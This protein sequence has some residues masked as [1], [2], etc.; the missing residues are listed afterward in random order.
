[1]SPKQMD[2]PSYLVSFLPEH[3]VNSSFQMVYEMLLLVCFLQHNRRRKQQISLNL[4][5]CVLYEIDLA[6]SKSP[7]F[8]KKHTQDSH[9]IGCFE[10]SLKPLIRYIFSVQ[11]TLAHP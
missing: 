6:L 3:M 4:D 8:V 11:H 9:N 5:E 2:V 7:M 1:M 10:Q